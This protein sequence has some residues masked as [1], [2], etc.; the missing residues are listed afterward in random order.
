MK[1][2]PLLLSSYILNNSASLANSAPLVNI[3]A[4]PISA[5]YHSMEPVYRGCGEGSVA[6]LSV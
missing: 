1:A 6:G 3:A 4:P 2:P 5:N